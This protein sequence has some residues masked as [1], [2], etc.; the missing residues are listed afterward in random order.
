MQSTRPCNFHYCKFTDQPRGGYRHVTRSYGRRLFTTDFGIAELSMRN[1]VVNRLWA[2]LCVLPYIKVFIP[3]VVLHGD[4]LKD[5]LK[6]TRNR[7]QYYLTRLAY[8]DI[9][10]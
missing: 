1:F 3:N 6:K 7:S 9:G 4:I 8:P 2:E 5:K 10:I